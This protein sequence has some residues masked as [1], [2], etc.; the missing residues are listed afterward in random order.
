[1]PISGTTILSNDYLT[2][3]KYNINIES[4]YTGDDLLLSQYI[5]VAITAVDNFINYTTGTTYD[6]AINQAIILY[7]TH[8]YLNRN[9]VS[10]AQGYELP[11]SF[12]FLLSP[13]KN[14]VIV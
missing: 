3:L 8:L 13:Y 10:F 12:K 1:M 14:Y 7:A 5:N 9:L 4:G 2:Y 11:Y 6:D